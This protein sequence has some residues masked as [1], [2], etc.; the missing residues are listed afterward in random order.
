MKRFAILFAVLLLMA[1]ALSK[2]EFVKGTQTCYSC[3][4]YG[5][6]AKPEFSINVKSPDIIELIEEEYPAVI[7][8]A[9]GYN[10]IDVI[11]YNTPKLAPYLTNMRG[12]IKVPVWI[13]TI[14]PKTQTIPGE[15]QAQETKHVSWTL[16]PKR[17]GTYTITVEASA[18]E[19]EGTY[20]KVF[21]ESKTVK[22]KVVPSIRFFDYGKTKIVYGKSAPSKDLESARLLKNY[23]EG[24]AKT[25][26]SIITDE[27]V[28]Q[29]DKE[30][31]NLILVGG[32]VAN[33]ITKEILSK[34][35]I[36]VSNM[37]PGWGRGIIN[38]VNNPFG[39]GTDVI[40]I[41]GSDRDGTEISA[42]ALTI[43]SG[44]IGSPWAK[45]RPLTEQ[46]KATYG[47]PYDFV[48]EDIY[49]KI[50]AR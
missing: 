3:H 6:G 25:S 46:E 47:Y 35:D 30:N 20:E 2:P 37:N 1:P 28:T 41:A 12:K 36:Q 9:R 32:P 23:I 42:R 5:G 38:R 34:M 39:T 10:K 44:K 49:G 43:W 7:E 21:T 50:F 27:E 16:I 17:G 11:F 18:Q 19:P 15:L 48:A 26:V 4:K 33:K 40:V 22:I 8:Q 45:I 13:K 29:E 14:E 31:Y 24:M